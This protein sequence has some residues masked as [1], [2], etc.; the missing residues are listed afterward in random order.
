MVCV[1]WPTKAHCIEVV[2]LATMKGYFYHDAWLIKSREAHVEMHSGPFQA[3]QACQVW[4]HLSLCNVA[5]VTWTF[6][7]LWTNYISPY[8]FLHFHTRG[9]LP[10]LQLFLS[11]LHKCDDQKQ[12][13]L[14][15]SVKNVLTISATLTSVRLLQ[16][17]YKN[18]IYSDPMTKKAQRK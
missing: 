3:D 5:A 11:T 14:N 8:P 17:L 4:I 9:W 1:L 10:A 13:L 18:Y 15:F 16:T 6:A 12:Y 2:M 7:L